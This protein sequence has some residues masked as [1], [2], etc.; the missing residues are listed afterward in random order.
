[1]TD[2]TNKGTGGGEEVAVVPQ[3]TF[4]ID[5]I[6]TS[7]PK[8]TLVI[9]A[10][11]EIG[12][13]IPR[14]CDHPL[15]EPV[16]A[17]RQ[18]L[19]EVSAPDRSGA[20]RPMP[21]PQPSCTL[22]ATDGMQ[23]STQRTSPV[24]EKAQRGM[25]ELLLINHPL[26]C[27]VCDKGGE[28][29]LQNQSMANGAATSRYLDVKRTF[30]KPIAVSTQILL[31]RE[32][33]VLCQRCTRFSD[34]IAGNPFIDLQKRGA[35]QQIGRFDEDVLDFERPGASSGDQ[36]VGAAH[37]D[38]SGAPFASYYSGNTVQ[39]CPVGALTSAA[40]RFRS[41]PFDLVSTPAVAEHD[42]CGSAI[43]VDH[44]RDT[45]MR[46]LA[47]DDPVVNEEWITDKDRFAFTWQTAPDR[48][49]TPLVRDRGEDGSR[50]ELRPASWSEALEAAA[51]GLARAREAGGVGVLPGG[52]LTIEDSFA[53]AKFARVALR[54]NDVDHRA[55]SHSAEESDFL[56][57]A[58]AG[59]GID[60]TFSDL[61][62]AP[63]VLLV[64]LEAEEEGGV[65]FLRLRKGAT[66]NDVRVFS[67]ASHASSGLDRMNGTLLAA[68]PGTEPEWLDQ[69]AAGGTDPAE[70]ADVSEALRGAGS[71]VLVG[72]R[73][74]AVPGAYSAVLRLV[75]RTGARL[76]WI[77][78]RIG[79]RAGV[80]TG[81]LPNLLPGG[82]PVVDPAARAEV[83]AL[84][85]GD[86][87]PADAGRST[88]EILDALWVG[89]LGG[90]LAGG[91]EPEDLPDP[92]HARRALEQA[93]FVVALDVRSSEVTERADVV[94]PVAP[95]AEK[96][97]SYWNWEG[98]VRTFGASL[99][100]DA[101]PD[102]RV[103]DALADELDVE[104]GTASLLDVR[105][106]LGRLTPWA[107]QRVAAP[108][109]APSEPEPVEPGTA[110]LASWR[111]QLDV[112]RLQDGERFLAGTAKRPVARISPV[113]AVAV[114]VADGEQ[115][116][117]S[118]DRGSLTL[119]VAVTAMV[120]HV[121]WVPLRSP[122]SQV[123]E[124]LGVAPG[125]VVRV[126]AAAGEG[127]A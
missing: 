2:T 43:R 55:R 67:I 9:R 18:C 73:L 70:L 22:V 71:V 19:V 85:G 121:V 4:Q 24:A 48:L 61:E 118:T 94:L 117:V 34:E 105:E 86:E 38:V 104:L 100:S 17:C 27:P 127:E 111:L 89:Q 84:W 41:R 44:R 62:A 58:V 77:P 74:A 112:A 123:H 90:V 14:F 23:V 68:A 66:K 26:D 78:R 47:S 20:V 16:G 63:S 29:P 45:V 39:I 87:L 54:T 53:Y 103:L 99:P 6:E 5:G 35:R 110:V 72:E 97:G 125:A 83:A 7:V 122:G 31:D 13:A 37:T 88:S 115:V 91:F 60:V 11:E 116:T 15:L 36:P 82:R 52:R 106:E 120:D 98:R 42:S 10:A 93:G 119:P 1:M 8:G 79:E 56:A 33:C 76:A 95:P 30:P 96:D 3:V 124:T 32:R 114:G 126:A 40:Y 28:C 69:I 92:A 65:T 81:T 80:E 113:T 64:G 12:I 109:V 25:L 102:H 57:H 59:R 101:M 75:E 49:T 107:G 46:R 108:T 50:G 51:E 21:K